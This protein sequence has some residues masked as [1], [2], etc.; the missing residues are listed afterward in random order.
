MK[1]R[2]ESVRVG[3]RITSIHFQLKDLA[4]F[5]L[6]NNT[7]LKISTTLVILHNEMCRHILVVGIVLAKLQETEGQS[8]FTMFY[9]C[10]IT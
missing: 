2:V 9:T 3:W 4:F 6:I 8:H 7:G 1:N 10:Y 5:F